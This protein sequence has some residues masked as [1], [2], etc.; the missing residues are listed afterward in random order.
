[1]RT[2][3]LV[4]HPRT[5]KDL[6][7]LL[8]EEEKPIRTTLLELVE[9]I[10]SVSCSDEE[11]VATVYYLVNEGFIFLDGAFTG[12]DIGVRTCK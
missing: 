12:E 6:V 9:V 2:Y 11:V 7:R 5:E 3:E 10:S 4:A 1:M 8:L